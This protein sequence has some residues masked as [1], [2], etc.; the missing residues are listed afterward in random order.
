MDYL[1]NFKSTNH[2]IAAFETNE[3]AVSSL[4]T[5]EMEGIYF[6]SISIISALQRDEQ[7]RFFKG[8]ADM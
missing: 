5:Y 3:R 2:L 6:S 1:I 7:D 4:S 8:L